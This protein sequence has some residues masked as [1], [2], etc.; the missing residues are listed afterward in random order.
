MKAQKFRLTDIETKEVSM[1]DRA[2]NQTKFLVVKREKKM[3]LKA[4]GKGGFV[5][6][7]EKNEGK[8]EGNKPEA[9]EG[10]ETQVDKGAQ[11]QMLA[12][13]AEHLLDIAK[14]IDA[15]EDLPENFVEQL[16]S[17][18]DNITKAEKSED[19]PAKTGEIGKAA[20]KLGE[21]IDELR[22]GNEPPAATA[23]DSSTKTDEGNNEIETLKAE[24]AELK[25]RLDK[26]EEPNDPKAAPVDNQGKSTTEKEDDNHW[27]M[28]MGEPN[29]PHLAG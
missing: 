11:V 16:G 15:G 20:Q 19:A 14:K 12:A 10:S 1:V 29:R 8:P 18:A 9:S 22:K 2:A 26:L 28:D 24:N 17:M 7:T 23:D 5:E 6:V 4:D 21:V 27:P 25:K 13:T 3:A